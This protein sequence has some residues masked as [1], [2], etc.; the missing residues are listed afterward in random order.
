LVKWISKITEREE[1]TLRQLYKKANEEDEPANW[2]AIRQYM[3]KLGEKYKF[4]PRKVS[5]D[6]R[7]RVYMLPGKTI[8]VVYNK[9]T[10]D[11]EKSFFEKNKAT[12]YMVA[13]RNVL[14]DLAIK[15]VEIE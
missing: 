4:D 9:K 5:I 2:E 1:D 11:I 7:G 6:T 15:E 8:F 13:D 3:D 14:Y 12:G 10:F